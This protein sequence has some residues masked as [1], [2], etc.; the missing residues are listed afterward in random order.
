M[1]EVVVDAFPFIKDCSTLSLFGNTQVSQNV[2]TMSP[3]PI[4]DAEYTPIQDIIHKALDGD[5]SL[6]IGYSTQLKKDKNNRK[7]FRRFFIP[8]LYDE[9]SI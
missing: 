9:V 4:F 5:M 1:N 8:A 2:P 7:Q 6:L 3:F